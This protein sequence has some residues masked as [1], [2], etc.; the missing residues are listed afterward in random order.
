M[1]AIGLLIVISL[2]TAPSQTVYEWEAGPLPA[3][4]LKTVNFRAWLP[5]GEGPVNGILFLIPGRHGDGRGMANDVSWQALGQEI[6]FAVVGCQYADGEPFP[7]QNDPGNSVSKSIEEAAE[8]LAELSGKA[9]LAKVPFAFWGHSAGSNVS[10]N[11][12]NYDPDRVVAFG[13]SKGTGGPGG[14]MPRGK[15][16]I[17][18]LFAI[19]KNDKAEWVKA[20][21]TSVEAGRSEKAPWVLALNIKEGHELGGSLNLIRPFLKWA[22]RLRLGLSENGKTSS[23]SVS[24]SGKVKLE[25]VS[26]KEGWLGDPESYEIASAENYSGKKKDAIWLPHE[27]VAKAWQGYLK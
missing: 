10:A 14:T 26:I 6:R 24:G 19:G 21:L 8:K 3:A 15:E 18:M 23:A 20:S 17:P 22:I 27:E 4:E 1:S 12:C 13:S 5:E 11:F 7:Y 9:E 16:E 2:S 25:K